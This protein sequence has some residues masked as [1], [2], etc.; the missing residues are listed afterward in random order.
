MSAYSVMHY[1]EENELE[2]WALLCELPDDGYCGIGAK[3]IVDPAGNRWHDEYHTTDTLEAA[4]ER[5]R[6]QEQQ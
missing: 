3:A 5:L 1:A 4:A 6:G 2:P